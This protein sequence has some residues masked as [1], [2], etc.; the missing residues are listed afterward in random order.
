MECCYIAISPMQTELPRSQ[1]ITK[2]IRTRIDLLA[3]K[4]RIPGPTFDGCGRAQFSLG[5]HNINPLDGAEQLL[6]SFMHEHDWTNMSVSFLASALCRE[7]PAEFPSSF[8]K[9]GNC[10]LCIGVRN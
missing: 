6:S 3:L 5:Q 2:T 10:F 7:T 1:V 4:P 8:L 9:K